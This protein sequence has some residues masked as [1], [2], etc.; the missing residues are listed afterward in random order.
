M[1]T[2]GGLGDL[3]QGIAT[4]ISREL[5]RDHQVAVGVPKRSVFLADPAA[6]FEQFLDQV[7]AA[8]G[9]NQLVL[10]LDEVIRLDE[11]VRAGR[12]DRKDFEYL[13]HLMQHHDRLNFVFALSSGIEEMSK[14]YAFLFSGSLY[15]RISFLE[16]S[17]ARDLVT[18]PARGHYELTDQAVDRILQVTSG[19][20]YY[21]QLVCH[22]VFDSWAR[23]P[24]A[25]INVGDVDNI[26][27]EAIELGSAN[28]TYVWLDSSPA[29]RAAMAGIAATIRGIGMTVTAVQVRDA[30]HDAGV[31][32]PEHE[33][34][35]AL[36]GL[37]EREVITGSGAHSFTVDLQRLWLDKHR[38]LE[39][40]KEELADAI[41]LWQATAQQPASR[42]EHSPPEA[43]D[44]KDAE[45]PAPHRSG[46]LEPPPLDRSGLLSD[47]AYSAGPVVEADIALDDTRRLNSA[48]RLQLPS[49]AQALRS[50]GRRRPRPMTILVAG[51]AALQA[52]LLVVLA[53]S[54][55]PS[56]PRRPAPS[57]SATS[58]AGG[59]LAAG[60]S[61]T[62][63]VD[64]VI[65]I[66]ESG[67]ETSQKIA[68][69]KASA[70]TIVQSMLNPKS[71][72]TVIGFGGVNHVAPNQDPVS[73][74]CQPTIASGTANLS[75][76]ST[77]VNGLHRRTEEEGDDTDYAAALEEAMSYLNPVST[78]RPPS[79]TGAIKVILMMTDG[80]VDVHRDTQQYGT[81]WQAGEQT[82][83]NEQLAV[84]RQDAVQLWPMG[85]GTDIGVG[86]TQPQA[87]AY[88]ENMAAKGA[89]AVCGTTT[90]KPAAIWVNDI[91]NVYAEMDTLYQDAA[92]IGEN[93]T[94]PTPLPSGQA[95]TLKVSIPAIAS[96]A[97]ISVARGNPEDSVAFY[98]PDGAPWTD[99]MAISGNDSASAVEVLHLTNITNADIGTW[100]VELTAPPQSAS[101]L[102]STA[103][104]WQGAVRAIITATPQVNPDKPIS[105]TLSVL[106]AN[107]PI[108]DPSTLKNLR[109]GVTAAGDGLPAAVAVPVTSATGS[110]S[111]GNYVGTFI[112]PN[113][114]GSLTI[115]GSA[116]GNGLQATQIPVT[117][118]VG[119]TSEF[120]A[121]PQF[122]VTAASVQA[123]K[124]ITGR[125]VFTNSTGATRNVRLRL[126][127]ERTGTT[128]VSP[129]GPIRVPTGDPPNV[130]FTVAIGKDSPTGPAEIIIAAIDAATG[131]VYASVPLQLTVI[132]PPGFL[133]KWRWIIIA[134]LILLTLIIV[135]LL[136]LRAHRRRNESVS[137][138]TAI[139]R[140]DGNQL[141]A[142]LKA[143]R[144]WSN[145][146]LF[147]IR[148]EGSFAPR[149]DWPQP[150]M[151]IYQVRRSG[152]G[153]VRLLTPTGDNYDIVVGGPGKRLEHNGLD[154]AFR[155]VR[156]TSPT[157]RSSARTS[158][159]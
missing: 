76:L 71:R 73:I 131:Q 64:A 135:G 9:D 158:P 144:K 38:R 108:T 101:Q 32:V 141:G 85:F 30:W 83:I 44:P 78:A 117:V 124:T 125:V 51:L 149:L 53:F 28:L 52:V 156:S 87:L 13:R 132:Q 118:T 60:L 110:N 122:Y 11:E 151:P 55:S 22:C 147:I 128:L 27:G 3:M 15:H 154:L 138:L 23:N 29:E 133:A 47:E 109:V 148:D 136:T 116:S 103:V 43:E 91:N 113:R 95:R 127:A 75:Y 24:A 37:T 93:A 58:A 143:P 107:G 50:A 81:D 18:C 79:P 25:I 62:Q 157:A 139:L 8:I 77:C 1:D 40:V 120:T 92:C 57:A 56:A 12:L 67:S 36:R 123:G 7:W 42:P 88:L 41:A 35:R 89:P 59:Q 155:E 100:Q 80:A 5:R 134:L 121:V 112:A 84:A 104:F 140:R 6:A 115:T 16:L 45:A 66:D 74:V 106:G 153:M 70:S 152:N 46:S 82:A 26:L 33:I 54:L 31:D 137:D 65:L 102:V 69:E 68:Q 10:M 159:T 86:V 34:T 97:A 145:V 20:P 39:W 21:T 129:T 126:T 146:F 90:G 96:G 105:I 150:G 61:M 94:P 114:Q 119:T 19:H 4:V 142:P 2:L 111:T 99:A 14:D 98:Q 72:V 130:P 49:P 63:P 48:G 17:A